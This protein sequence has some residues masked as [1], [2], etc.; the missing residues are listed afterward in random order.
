MSQRNFSIVGVMSLVRYL[1]CPLVG[2]SGHCPKTDWGPVSMSDKAI[3]LIETLWLPL[4]STYSL[5]KKKI[6]NTIPLS[7]STTA[8]PPT[9]TA[10]D[11]GQNANSVVI[12]H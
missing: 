10:T 12:T 8:S 2:G 11:V 9:A 7:F 1:C 3:A 6:E 5:K 4:H